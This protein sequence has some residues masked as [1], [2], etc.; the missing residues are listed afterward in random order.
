MDIIREEILGWW[1]LPGVLSWGSHVASWQ[2][3]RDLLDQECQLGAA[4][5]GVAAGGVTARVVWKAVWWTP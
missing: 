5:L 2:L 1:W 4:G 3:G